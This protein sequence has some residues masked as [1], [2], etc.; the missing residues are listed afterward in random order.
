[1]IDRIFGAGLLVLLMM[2]PSMGFQESG[3]SQPAPGGTPRSPIEKPVDLAPG[4]TFTK[5]DS[6]TT[7]KIPGLG[8]LGVLPKLDFGLEL[9]YGDASRQPVDPGTDQQAD[10]DGLRIKGTLKHRF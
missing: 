2:S 9:L 6:G 8:A 3:T 4:E 10:N 5:P 7:V 1:M